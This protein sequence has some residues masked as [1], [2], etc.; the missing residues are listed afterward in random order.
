MIPGIINM[1]RSH[2]L[3]FLSIFLFLASQVQAQR[4]EIG[5]NWGAASYTGEL[6]S[7]KIFK[8]SGVNIGVFGRLNYDPHWSLGVH[9]NYGNIQGD[10]YD[11]PN[12]SIIPKNVSFSLPKNYS[13]STRLYEVSAIGQFNFIDM[14]SPGK[15]VRWSPYLLGGFGVLLFTPFVDNSGKS[16]GYD[17]FSKEAFK[18]YSLVVPIGAGLKFKQTEALTWQASFGYRNVFNEHLDVYSSRNLHVSNLAETASRKRDAYL[19]VNIGISYTFV[20]PKCFT[21]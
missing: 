7:D 19:F 8:P 16:A 15:K 20:S 11:L 13:F 17:E 3:F 6:N 14:Y 5:G 21:F 9:V 18:K 10:T 2:F 12:Y 1:R 4:F